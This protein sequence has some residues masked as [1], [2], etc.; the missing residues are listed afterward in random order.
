LTELKLTSLGIE[1]IRELP[2]LSAL[3]TLEVLSLTDSEPTAWNEHFYT[4]LKE[5]GQWLESCTK[6]KRLELRKFMDDNTLLTGVLLS[7]V[8][9]LTSLSFAG[10]RLSDNSIFSQALTGQKSLQCLYL[11]GEGSDT[12]RNNTHLVAAIAE[13]HN[14]RELELKDVSDG[15]N[16]QHVEALTPFLPQLERLWISGEAFNDSVWNA[17]LNLPK[18]KS[19]S[20]YAL[21]N[22]TATGVVDFISQ[23]GPGNMGFSLSILNAVSAISF[24]EEAQG[25][26]RE[27]LAE[28]MD[29]SFDFGLAQGTSVPFRLDEGD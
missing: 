7:G 8:F 22:F 27:M 4:T 14:L 6:L 19:L 1:T 28:N 10:L 23:L 15:F 3:P 25:M 9:H 20:I 24:P 5:V 17:F 13:L 12:P 26:I 29:G 2:S 21:S 11:R 18:L 16:I